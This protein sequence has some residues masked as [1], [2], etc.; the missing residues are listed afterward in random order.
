MCGFAV[1][2]S[3]DKRYAVLVFESRKQ[4]AFSE[5]NVRRI[6]GGSENKRVS[7]LLD[8]WSD[9]EPNLQIAVEENL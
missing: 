6:M 1:T 4:R 5:R 7:L 3:S 2:N 8:M 9:R